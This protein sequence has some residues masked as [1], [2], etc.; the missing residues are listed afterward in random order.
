MLA[1]YTFN[2]LNIM[3][4]KIISVL[5]LSVFLVLSFSNN[6]YANIKQKFTI[7]SYKKYLLDTN[8]KESLENFNKLTIK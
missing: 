1:D 4:K 3:I 7:E 2:L 6:T 5:L 8:N